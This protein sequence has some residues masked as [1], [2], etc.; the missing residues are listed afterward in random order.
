M[1]PFTIQA[2]FE[3]LQNSSSYKLICFSV[4]KLY[5][6]RERKG[7]SFQK[8]KFGKWENVRDVYDSEFLFYVLR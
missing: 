7:I 3:Y 8:I 4:S 5:L 1:F 6:Y 2:S